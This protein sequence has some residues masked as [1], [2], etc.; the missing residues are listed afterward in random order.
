[1]PSGGIQA[2]DTWRMPVH[3]WQTAGRT[4]AVASFF[5]VTCALPTWKGWLTSERAEAVCSAGAGGASSAHRGS[6]GSCHRPASRSL[7]PVSLWLKPPG[8]VRVSA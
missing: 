5:L 2:C 6:L 1:M 7:M 4:E 3:T 8:L